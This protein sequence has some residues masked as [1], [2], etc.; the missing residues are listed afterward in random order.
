[1]KSKSKIAPLSQKAQSTKNGKDERRVAA[2]R[3]IALRVAV[4]FLIVVFL[5]GECAV[6]LPIQ[7]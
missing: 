7:P 4:V 6:L 2:W 1:M 5:A 3:G